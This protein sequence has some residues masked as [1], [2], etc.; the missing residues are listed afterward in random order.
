MRP[1]GRLGQVLMGRPLTLP[2][3]PTQRFA[4]RARRARRSAWLP[5][6]QMLSD[7]LDC[8]RSALGLAQAEKG[9][10]LAGMRRLYYRR[11][12]RNRQ[13]L[14]PTGKTNGLFIIHTRWARVLLS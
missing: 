13:S 5:D 6:R 2:E 3:E 14:L 9:E 12:V 11:E 10:D 7:Q 4:G 1:W 8:R